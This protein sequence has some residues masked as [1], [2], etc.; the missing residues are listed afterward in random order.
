MST[1][2]P[3]VSSASPPAPTT[4]Q[5]TSTAGPKEEEACLS[6]QL[7]GG[8]V[9]TIFGTQL[10]WEGRKH[11][12]G[13]RLAGKSPLG[14]VAMSAMGVGMLGVGL[15]RWFAPFWR[16]EALGTTAAKGL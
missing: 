6:C 5:Q 13:A 14:A 12:R 4:A 1:F 2:Q 8:G 9:L 15:H 7:I 3:A 10:I 11:M 16:R